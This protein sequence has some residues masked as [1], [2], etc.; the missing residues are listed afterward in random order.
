MSGKMSRAI[1][2]DASVARAAGSAE[3]PV[4]TACRDFLIQILRICHRVV[5]TVEI[6]EE[7]KKHQSGFALRWRA[8]ME[9][10]RKV[11]RP[12]VAE[13]PSG[14]REQAEA[15][16]LPPRRMSALLKDLH[17]VEAALATD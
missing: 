11:V 6:A 17:L 15:L 8:A 10:K 2:I 13:L 7:W 3:H 12:S 5:M 16:P 14:L 4:S 9:S 1:V